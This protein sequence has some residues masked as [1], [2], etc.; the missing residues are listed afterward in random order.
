VKKFR[1]LFYG[2]FLSVVLVF[3]ARVNF[4]LLFAAIFLLFL[5]FYNRI[6]Q[7]LEGKWKKVIFYASILIMTVFFLAG[8]LNSVYA[9]QINQE[10]LFFFL[11]PGFFLWTEKP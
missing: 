9:S 8:F 1:F 2:V 6:V 11:L 7:V 3:L 5:L 10:F 4:Y